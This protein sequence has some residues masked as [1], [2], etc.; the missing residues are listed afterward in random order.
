MPGGKAPAVVTTLEQHLSRVAMAPERIAIVLVGASAAVA[1]AL[2]VLGLYRSNGR[3]RPSATARVRCTRGARV[4]GMATGATGR[5]R[6]RPA[7][8]RRDRRGVAPVARRR[9]LD[10]TG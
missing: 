2:G 5:H 1:L 7:C 6:R 4:A 10:C 3:R 8:R 9:T